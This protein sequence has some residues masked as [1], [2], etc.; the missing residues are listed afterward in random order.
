MRHGDVDSART[1]ELVRSVPV[2]GLV[3]GLVTA[4]FGQDGSISVHLVTGTGSY[5]DRRVHVEVVLDREHAGI[6]GE[7]LLG[8][9]PRASPADREALSVP[10]CIGICIDLGE[11]G[12]LGTQPSSA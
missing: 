8:V 5:Q 12:R 11:A 3:D 4:A 1:A 10:C 9:R 2:P 7:T 6:L